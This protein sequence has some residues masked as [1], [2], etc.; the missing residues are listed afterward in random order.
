MANLKAIKKQGT[1][2]QIQEELDRTTER[3][4]VDSRECFYK[5][6]TFGVKLKRTRMS[7]SCCEK[8]YKVTIGEIN[9][10]LR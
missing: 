3:F 9:F 4:G 1:V 7:G 5:S 8:I 2:A 10:S 6:K